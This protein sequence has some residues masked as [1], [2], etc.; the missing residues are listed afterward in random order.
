MIIEIKT[1]PS[2]VLESLDEIVKIVIFGEN[3]LRDMMVQL[4]TGPQIY[5]FFGLLSVNFVQCSSL[6]HYV[7]VT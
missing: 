7:V 2:F 1:V 5:H 4:W 3:I 6:M